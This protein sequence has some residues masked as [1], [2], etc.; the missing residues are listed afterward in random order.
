MSKLEEKLLE[1]GYKQL[2]GKSYFQKIHKNTPINI[3]VTY[4]VSSIDCLEVGEC[5]PSYTEEDAL[6]R[7]ECWKILNEDLKILGMYRE[8]VLLDDK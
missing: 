7:V 1:L 2:P 8:G 4:K 3:F 5:S 6:N